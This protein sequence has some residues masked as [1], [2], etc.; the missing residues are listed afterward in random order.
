LSTK[1][2]AGADEKDAQK[3]ISDPG[4]DLLEQL[5]QQ[6]REIEAL[7]TEPNGERDLAKVIAELSN[8]WLP[9]TM[10]EEQL[11][12]PALKQSGA[13]EPALDEAEVRRDLVK[14]L[15]AD[16]QQD[17]AGPQTAAKFLV[18][19]SELEQ[20]IELEE[21]PDAGVL[22]LAKSHQVDLNA[23]NGQIDARRAAIQFNTEGELSNALELT[24][25]RFRRSGAKRHLE[26]Y[27]SMPNGSSMRER[28]ERGRFESDGDQRGGYR[29]RG[30]DRDRDENGR[31]MSDDDRGRSSRSSRD[32][33][34]D[35]RRSGGEGRD[36]DGRFT[37]HSS[38]QRDDGDRRGGDD[39]RG[40]YG[41]SGGHSEA[42]RRGWDSREGAGYSS[43]SSRDE[44]NNRGGY[45]SS[46]NDRDRDEN[47]RFMSDGDRGGRSQ[48]G[49]DEDYRRSGS[50]DGGPRREENGRFTSGDG[51]SSRSSQYDDDRR[52]NGHN[53]GRGWHGDSRGHAEAARE[54]WEDRRSGGYSSRSSRQEED[55]DRRNGGREHGGWFGDSR[56][57]SEAARRGWDDRH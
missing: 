50:S 5:K 38:S 40:W 30:D 4:D 41:D 29:S 7:I 39:N 57:H 47:G 31:F 17:S 53:E 15:L 55:D 12:I 22:S 34:D 1:K 3:V 24:A 9:H 20:L 14:I 2:A 28:D 33:D 52:G 45:R 13:D 44:D 25:L 49:S 54:G 19:G 43:R 42:S 27:S 6:H 46:G 18:L 35:H 21:R 56:G 51:S 11:F 16:L 32:Y 23:L 48:R 8:K 37:S 10:I 26:E 36:E